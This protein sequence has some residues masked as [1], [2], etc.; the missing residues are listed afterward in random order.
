MVSINT[1][2][3]GNPSQLPLTT[4][5]GPSATSKDTLDKEMVREYTF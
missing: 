2:M 3:T 1:N 5:V 4:L